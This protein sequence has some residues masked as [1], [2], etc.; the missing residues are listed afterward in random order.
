MRADDAG[1][2]WLA[3]VPH[4][5]PVPVGTMTAIIKQ[6]GLTGDEFVALLDG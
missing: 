6:A 4:H 5:D 2:I 3:I 1:R